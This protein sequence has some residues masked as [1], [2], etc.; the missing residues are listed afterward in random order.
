M[1]LWRGRRCWWISISDRSLRLRGRLGPTR[2]SCNRCRTFSSANRRGSDRLCRSCRRRQSWA[3]RRK[4]CIFRRGGRRST[5]EPSGCLP[6]PELPKP[7]PFCRPILNLRTGQQR[8]AMIVE[9]WSWFLERK[10]RRRSR[11]RCRLKN[12]LRWRWRGS[13]RRSNQ[14]P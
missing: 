6:T 10:R 8:R 11:R 5:C 1:W 2:R 3:W 14:R 12:L 13:R 9:N 7:M 4:A